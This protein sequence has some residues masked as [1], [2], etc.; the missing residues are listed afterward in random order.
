MKSS[1]IV[2]ILVRVCFALLFATS[3]KGSKLMEVRPVD[4]D[5]LMLYFKDGETIFRDDGKGE[6]AFWGH[7]F[8][9][10][11]DFLVSYGEELNVD[12]VAEVANWTI[13]S[14]DDDAYGMQGL[15]PEVVYRKSKGEQHGPCLELQAR[16][17]DFP[18]APIRDEAAQALRNIDRFGDPF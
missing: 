12:A 6:S 7:K 16:P 18:Q 17:L 15:R 3:L 1:P 13:R 9:E 2:P 11:D 8:V 10:G 4:Q 5:Y 14:P